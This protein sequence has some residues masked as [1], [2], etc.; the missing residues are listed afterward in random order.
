MKQYSNRY[1]REGET[2]TKPLM[3]V[4]KLRN[5]QTL[6]KTK[7]KT[8]IRT[9]TIINTH[10]PEKD[11]TN[12]KNNDEEYYKNKA[13]D[14]YAETKTLIKTLKLTAFQTPTKTKTLIRTKMIIVT[15][16]S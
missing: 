14:K 3:N 13:G 16:A 10:A 8:L 6:M 11:T 2:L 9:K 4:Q 5:P 7:T 15:Q 12:K 1:A